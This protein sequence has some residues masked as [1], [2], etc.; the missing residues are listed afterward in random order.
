MQ[1]QKT[2]AYTCIL[3]LVFLSGCG[4]E[5]ASLHPDV[6]AAPYI[7]VVNNPLL[8]FTQ[9]LIANE[10]DVRLLVS[11][12]VDPAAW[13]PT[14]LDVLQLQGA[15]LLLLNGAGYSSWQDRVSISP[16]KIVVTSDAS[17][18]RWLELPGQVT[19]S[20]GPGT[21]HAHGNYAITTWM[22]MSLAGK[23]AQAIA[24]ALQKRWPRLADTVAVRLQDLI[25]DIDALDRGYQAQARRL[26]HRNIIYSHPVYQYFE[27]RY[28]LPGH[29]LH[30]EPDVMPSDEQWIELQ[31]I[32]SAS[33]LFIWEGNPD[34][35]I[36]VRMAAQAIPFVVVD[37][38]ANTSAEDW[39]SIQQGNLTRLSNVG[40]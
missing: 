31:A 22:D 40:L 7:V 12:G 6:N 10:A 19:H 17:K 39:L 14:A 26:A 25:A 32:L 21:E 24:D 13:Q 4:D 33:S 29:S 18:D 3:L 30:W 15:E 38:A 9:R 11:P 20:H 1:L 35:A 16:R 23:Q 5:Q 2:L 36:S 27:R 34:T 28:Q 8:Y 37:P